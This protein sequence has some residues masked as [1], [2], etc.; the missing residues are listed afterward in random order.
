MP[1]T[2]TQADNFWLCMDEPVN[3][4]VITGFW[5]FAEPL[6]YNRL[7]A[8][9]EARLAS[10]PRFRQKVVRP[11]TGLGMPKWVEDKHYDLAS[12]LHRVALPAPGDKH[13]LS[14]MISNL[15]TMAL[16]QSKPLWDIHLIENYK[17]GCAL[18]FRLHHCI[19]DGIALMHVL[20]STADTIPDAPWPKKPSDPKK[21]IAGR[22]QFFSFNSMISTAKD[23][24][25]KGQEISKRIVKEIE[26]V[27]A[28]PDSLK[29][30]LKLAARL[31]SDVAGVLSRHTLMNSDPNTAFKGKLQVAKQVTW[32]DPIPLDRIKKLGKAI[33]SATLNDVLIATV[34]GSMR[35][36]LKTK[37]TPINELDLRVTVP[38]NIRKP[39]TEFE[40]GNKFSL[41]FLKLP[42]Y[43]EDPIL[44][45]KEVKR[46]MDKLKVS[47]DPYV[48]FGLLSAI[49]F[50]PS[51]MAQ[52]AAQ[53]F[54]NK[55]SG[56]MTNVP[57]PK[58][59]LYFADKEIT[60]IMFWVP[61]SGTVGLGIS[62]LSYNNRVTIGIASDKGLM[63]D[64]EVLLGGFEEEFNYLIDIVQSG[65]IY[66]APLVLHDRF[67]EKKETTS[68]LVV[69]K[70]EPTEDT[71]PVQCEAYTK[72]GKKCKNKAV[73]GTAFCARHQ[74]Y[75]EEGSL[76]SDVRQIM[77]DLS[78]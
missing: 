1:E 49:G 59:P 44:R 19:A 72:D 41:V 14:E 26:N 47:A 21:H 22:H 71:F 50:L 42:V 32:T 3:L 74:Q 65:K 54:G 25:Q 68:K 12:H 13:E 48:N 62:I 29:F 33:S 28:N 40:L 36:Y 70:A 73:Q 2:M 23:A 69:E 75:Q 31:P 38:V 55:A 58:K 35:R 11:K 77:R 57:G 46:R 34:T 67:A 56:V 18:F 7:Y 61:R 51:S 6:D 76:L 45:L 5:E 52:K 4:M 15:M 20:H 39:G 43:L 16:D 30:M 78:D 27:S 17:T 9:V 8:T 66:E 63:P 10:F 24:I 37:N 53:F 60:N 64:P